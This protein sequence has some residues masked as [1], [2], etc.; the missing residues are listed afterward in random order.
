MVHN[1]SSENYYS[2]LVIII[3]ANGNMTKYL[4]RKKGNLTLNLK[5]KFYL[6]VP[7]QIIFNSRSGESN[8]N[9]SYAF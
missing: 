1:T 3:L 6:I 7:K 5:T 2:R 8:F 9:C 4:I